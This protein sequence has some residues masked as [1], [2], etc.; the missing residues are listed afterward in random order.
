MTDQHP[1]EPHGIDSEDTEMNPITPQQEMAEQHYDDY[2]EGFGGGGEL[3]QRPRTKFLSPITAGLMA[4]ILGGV[5]FYVGIRVEKSSGGGSSTS[6]GF[7]SRFAAA[8]G[9]TNTTGKTSSTGRTRA[10][11][12]GAGFAGGFGGAAG[13]TTGT[14]SSIDGDTLYVKETSGDTV[15]VKLTGSTTVSKSES[16]SKKKIYPGD[17][18]SVAGASGSGGTVSATSVTDSGASTSTSSGSS[19]PSSSSTGASSAVNS[20][21]GG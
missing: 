9:G 4:L 21:F 17:T 2:D 5:G 12:S 3:P 10:F 7:A 19:T 14:V 1:T 11:A 16:V 20:L 6:S 18:V 13:G 15:K 8:V